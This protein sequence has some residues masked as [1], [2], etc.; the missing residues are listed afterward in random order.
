[1]AREYPR[2]LFS[3]PQNTKST[4]PFVIHCLEPRLIFRVFKSNNEAFE[5]DGK[6]WT[7]KNGIAIILLTDENWGKDNRISEVIEAAKQWT[8][9]QIKSGAINL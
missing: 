2:F 9:S 1:M 6:P 8:V 4:G 3:D 5:T 7:V